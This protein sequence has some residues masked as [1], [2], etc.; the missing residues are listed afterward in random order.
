MNPE[1][2]DNLA[3]S[4][5][6]ANAVGQQSAE[7]QK[8]QYYFQEENKSIAEMQLEVE[9]ILNKCYHL[10]RQD[11]IKINKGSEEWE[12]VPDE[13]KRVLTDEGVDRIMQV[14]AF[15]IN[16]E[17]LLSNF[18]EIMIPRIMRT[19]RFSLNANFFM[20][21]QEL[22]REPTIE[23]C[24]DILDDRL[25]EKKK[26]KMFTAEILGIDAQEKEV[27]AQI[28]KEIE[29][30]IEKEIEHIRIQKRKE[31]LMEWELIFEQLSQIVFATM[32]RAWRGEERGSIRRHTQISEVLG[33]TMPTN[34]KKKGGGLFSWGGN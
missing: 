1:E 28:L 14:M 33:K 4:V 9:G 17:N 31:N 16:K 3:R 21:Y 8:Q 34:E 26:I 6:L 19:F 13:K 22:F 10:L 5:D 25:K 18:D 29:G 11:R 12:A 23:E 15:Y 32:N 27:E 24:R 7:S 20:K 30:R 2:Q